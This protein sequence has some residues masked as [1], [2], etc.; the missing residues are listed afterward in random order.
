MISDPN[1]ERHLHP[2]TNKITKKLKANRLNQ[3][4][5]LVWFTGLSG[6]G[7]STLANLLETRLFEEGFLTCVLDGDMIR[8]GL[9][10]DLGFSKEDRLENIRRIGEVSKLMMDSGLVVISAFISPFQAD[11]KM[12]A[13]MV[14]DEN[15]LEVFVDCPLEVCEHRDVKGLYQKARAGVIR[16]FTGI[17]SPYEPP[18]KPRVQVYSDKEELEE[19]LE[20]I[21]QV[22]LPDL[23]L[24]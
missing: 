11:R 4:P 21:L 2:V 18:V 23:K 3:V 24:Y 6:S 1:Q 7:K 5:K 16:D 13:Q 10:K 8:T 22:V 20:K 17:D 14:G 15:F 19:S 12:I 9:N